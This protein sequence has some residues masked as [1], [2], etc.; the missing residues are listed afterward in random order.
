MRM[1]DPEM[2]M[3]DIIKTLAKEKTAILQGDAERIARQHGEGKCTA[4]ERVAKLFDAALWKWTPCVPT[5]IWWPV[6]A[7]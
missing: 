2:D 3:S 4:R 7:P 5:A 6:T 1:G